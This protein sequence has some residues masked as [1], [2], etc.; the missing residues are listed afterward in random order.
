MDKVEQAGAVLLRYT[1]KH[2]QAIKGVAGAMIFMYGANF[3]ASLLMFQAVGATGLP[4]M[5]KNLNELFNTYKATRQTFKDEMPQI[6]RARASLDETLALK[7]DLEQRL[8]DAEAQYRSGT[9]SKDDFRATAED[10]KRELQVAKKQMK[11]LSEVSS[12][13][14]RIHSA[15]NPEHLKVLHP[16]LLLLLLLLLLVLL[17]LLLLLLLR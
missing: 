10:I 1:R 3:P 9:L 14:K 7:N 2:R 13:M 17:V 11:Q 4:G 6:L 5:R 12:S 8:R 15:V 16:L